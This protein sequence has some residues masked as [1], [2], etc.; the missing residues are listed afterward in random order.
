MQDSIEQYMQKVGQQ[1]REA[2]RV[3][4]SAST[5]LKNHALSAIYTAL[6]NN[7]AAILA[8]NQIDME[9]GVATSSTVPYLIVL[10]LRPHA[11]KGCCKV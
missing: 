2:S 7:Q 1:A 5:S 10:S 3:L 9:K 11:L 6:E 4:T 8:A